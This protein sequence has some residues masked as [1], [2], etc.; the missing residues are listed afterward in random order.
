[1]GSQQEVV[2]TAVATSPPD[3]LPSD[4]AVLVHSLQAVQQPTLSF[5]PN[6]DAP[7]EIQISTGHVLLQGRTI[8]PKILYTTDGS[9]P[10]PLEGG[11]DTHLYDDRRRPALLWSA[12][13]VSGYVEFRAIAVVPGMLKS[14]VGRLEWTFEVCDAPRVDSDYPI[15]PTDDRAVQITSRT[16]GC[17]IHYSTRSKIPINGVGLNPAVYPV[18]V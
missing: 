3:M 1:M 15:N 10:D 11:N 2:I 7:E 4:P 9:D 16:Q 18:C 12:L 13:G 8:A 17:T 5:L 6:I 14:A